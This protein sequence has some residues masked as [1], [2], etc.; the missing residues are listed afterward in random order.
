MAD[1]QDRLDVRPV[2]PVWR[3]ADA[4][5]LREGLAPGERLVVSELPSPVP[6]MALRTQPPPG[7][8][9]VSARSTP[10]RSTP[11]GGGS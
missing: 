9:A 5:L 8:P 10:P 3:E 1:A 4:V 7:T 6:G 2:E 11:T